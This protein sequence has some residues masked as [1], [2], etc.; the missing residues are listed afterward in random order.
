MRLKRWESPRKEGR[1][2]KG[3]GGSARQRQL[4]KQQQMLRKRLKE[5]KNTDSQDKNN[6]S[7]GKEIYSSPSFFGYMP[8]NYKQLFFKQNYVKTDYGRME[9]MIVNVIGREREF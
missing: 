2:N 1:N 9:N 5:D 7:G 8:E 6:S 3:R 4:K